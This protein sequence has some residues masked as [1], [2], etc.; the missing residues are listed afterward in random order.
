MSQVPPC[1]APACC[2]ASLL[3]VLVLEAKEDAGQVE[4]VNLRVGYPRQ[5]LHLVQ[6]QQGVLADFKAQ[7]LNT[8]VATAVAEEGLDLSQCR[9]VV[10][11]FL[12][13]ANCAMR[14]CK[15]R[16]VILLPLFRNSN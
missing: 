2:I 10:R 11:P 3:Q 9:L 12:T 13:G 15:C 1:C 16:T 7:K 14:W 5:T 4:M 8:L 6:R